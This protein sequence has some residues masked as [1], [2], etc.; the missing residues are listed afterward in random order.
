MWTRAMAAIVDAAT[1][2]AGKVPK[3]LW[4][5]GSVSAAARGALVARGWRI[6]E[7]AGLIPVW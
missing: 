4:L 3:H 2:A 1:A 5:T 6:E 7:N